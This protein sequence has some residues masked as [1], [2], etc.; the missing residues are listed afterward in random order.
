MNGKK[1]REELS[2]VFK[3]SDKSIQ[4]AK[5]LLEE[6]PDLATQVESCTASLAA[7]YDELKGRRDAA[8]R[9]KRDLGRVA[10]YR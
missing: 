8:E 10:E 3:V 2:A 1:S 9:K 6:A 5:A 4:Q 7:A